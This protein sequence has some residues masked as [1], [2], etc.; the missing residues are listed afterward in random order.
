M[1]YSSLT[2]R[3]VLGLALAGASM[4]GRAESP[5]D[6]P[7][8][9]RGADGRPDFSGIWQ[10]LSGADYGLEPH[11]ATLDEPPGA[12]VVEGNV[13][14]Y[15]PAALAQRAKNFADRAA[16]D[17]RHKCFTLGTPRGLYS[18]EPFQIFQ[19]PRDL[20]VLFEFGHPVRTI[21]TNGTE[22]PDGHIDFWLGD[23][24]GHWEG[25]TLVVDVTDFNGETWLDRVGNFNSDELHLVEHWSFV[26]R[27]TI[28]Y[29]AT[30]ND[31][32]VYTKP[33]TLEVLLY[34]RLEPNVQIIEN[35]CATLEYDQYYPVPSGK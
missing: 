7:N 17:P 35:Y 27:N 16:A 20:T 22:H 8:L 11:L 4:I 1:S 18:N 34:R 26:D 28:R 5:P 10:S 2:R 24:R 6:Q 12:G 9:P 3:I 32:K 15:R 25:D 29:R 23:S 31:P 14:P 19:R 30:F 21:N 13:I 33:W